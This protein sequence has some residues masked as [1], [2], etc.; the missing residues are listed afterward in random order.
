MKLRIALLALGLFG[1]GMG[2]A[3]L[4]V[5][6]RMAFDAKGNE[7]EYRTKVF[8]V[9]KGVDPLKSFF[10]PVD[11]K[12]GTTYSLC[13]GNSGLESEVILGKGG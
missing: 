11:E 6:R 12:L 1:A 2:R 13:D 10:V 4:R 3:E 8:T 7:I 9:K 5:Y